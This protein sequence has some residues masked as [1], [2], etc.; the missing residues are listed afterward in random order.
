MQ[1]A[2]TGSG[3]L[4]VST[5][6]KHISEKDGSAFVDQFG[7]SLVSQNIVHAECTVHKWVPQPGGR[8]TGRLGRETHKETDVKKNLHTH[9]YI[10]ISPTEAA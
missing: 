8:R 4:R 9:L 5:L 3:K 1:H 7:T 2:P 6:G 10:P